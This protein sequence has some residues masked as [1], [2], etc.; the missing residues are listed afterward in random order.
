MNNSRD[1][2]NPE[3]RPYGE[4]KTTI[5]ASIIKDKRTLKFARKILD[6]LEK[7]FDKI[8]KEVKQCQVTPR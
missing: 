3:V 2:V 8:E 6:C 4:L 5:G 1:N 7:E